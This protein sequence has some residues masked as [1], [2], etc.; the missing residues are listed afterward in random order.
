MHPN[1]YLT[2]VPN[3]GGTLC[4]KTAAPNALYRMEK[5]IRAYQRIQEWPDNQ[6]NIVK[7]MYHSPDKQS[8]WIEYYP[9]GSIG[10]F[11]GK[12]ENRFHLTEQRIW[13]WAFQI[14]SALVYMHTGRKNP[15]DDVRPEGWLMLYHQ[16]LHWGNVLLGDNIDLA[17]LTDFDHSMLPPEPKTGP[18]LHLEEAARDDVRSLGEMLDK[19][20]HIGHSAGILYSNVLI[21]FIDNMT[22]AS[23]SEVFSSLALWKAMVE[24]A[25]AIEVEYSELQG[26]PYSSVYQAARN[27]SMRQEY[28]RYNFRDV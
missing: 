18:N 17:V 16:D 25:D 3:D 9:K 5:E 26:Q 15:D 28:L 4:M 12:S 19:I 21:F 8:I 13:T 23:E 7:Y 20:V 14:L 11:L 2:L 1:M 6:P 10:D 27:V 22:S 24:M